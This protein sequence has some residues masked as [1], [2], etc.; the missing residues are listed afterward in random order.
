[1]NENEKRI[2][3]RFCESLYHVCEAAGSFRPLTELLLKTK[4]QQK[5]DLVAWLDARKSSNTAES[6]T[7][8]A[9]KTAMESSLSAE[10]SQIDSVVSKL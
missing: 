7:L 2:I 3:D 1:M 6:G 9:K 4:V 8:A 5:A 10:N